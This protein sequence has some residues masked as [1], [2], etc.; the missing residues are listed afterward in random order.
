ML[1][2]LY[3]LEDA[4][5]IDL[6]ELGGVCGLS[7]FMLLIKTLQSRDVV[8]LRLMEVVVLVRCKS[9]GFCATLFLFWK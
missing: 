1:K 7:S 4:G 2:N 9:F 5:V 3:L 6:G 8:V